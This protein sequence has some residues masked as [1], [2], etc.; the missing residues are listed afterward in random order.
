MTKRPYDDKQHGD[1]S[2]VD[3]QMLD[4]L[5]RQA[6]RPDKAAQKTRIARVMDHVQA[7]EAIEH[8]GEVSRVVSTTE[9]NSRRPRRT[10]RRWSSTVIAAA[11]VLIVGLLWQSIDPGQS[12][13]ATVQK[14]LARA[15]EPGPR[16]Y[17]F[18]SLVRT[19]V[20]G[21]REFSGSLYLNGE[22]QFALR[23][24]ALL[25]GRDIWIGGNS[26]ENW[27][28]PGIGPVF[29]GDDEMLRLW[30][31]RE[32]LSTPYLHMTTLLEDLSNRYE[33]ESLP[34]EPAAGR[35]CRR[36]RGVK[37]DPQAGRGPDLIDLWADERTGLVQR[38]VLDWQLQPNEIGCSTVQLNLVNQSPLPPD[39][40]EHTAHHSGRST[41]SRP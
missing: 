36:V 18:K 24:P 28:V 39:W 20:Q 25:P 32:E 6:L 31:G 13:S 23:H 33:L 5:L 27:I 8:V 4:A 37:L 12:A 14:S 19:P 11:V 9:S 10:L 17:Q 30:S 40:F 26:R 7:D 35:P 1:C 3:L 16:E 38:V 15:M 21:D 34:D 41:V 22:Q 2:R 29:V